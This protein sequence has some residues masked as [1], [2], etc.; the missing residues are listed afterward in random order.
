MAV[1]LI[2]ISTKSAVTVTRVEPPF[3]GL[4]PLVGLLASRSGMRKP[5]GTVTSIRGL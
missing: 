4:K 3:N 1:D 5:R 2:W